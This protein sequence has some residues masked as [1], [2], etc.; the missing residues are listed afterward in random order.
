ME[1]VDGGEVI[2]F[3]IIMFITFL[4]LVMSCIGYFV[5]NFCKFVSR[6]IIECKFVTQFSDLLDV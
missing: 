6:N 2:L 1:H 5:L 4:W 3:N